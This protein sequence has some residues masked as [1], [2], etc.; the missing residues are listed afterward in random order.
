MAWNDSFNAMVLADLDS[1]F[2]G[3]SEFA[4]SVVV[5]QKDQAPRTI[6]CR[7]FNG[8]NAIAE[9]A[10][11][12]QFIGNIEVSAY[13]NTV[14]GIFNPQV[15]DYVIWNGE[16]FNFLSQKSADIGMGIFIFQNVSVTRQGHHRP[17]TL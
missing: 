16:T 10:E 11:H 14:T 9:G 17:P 2:F 7:V 1:S 5:C 8:H 15:G 3:T 4:D 6:V 13:E 12:Q